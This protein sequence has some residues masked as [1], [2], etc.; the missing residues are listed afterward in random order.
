VTQRRP[1]RGQRTPQNNSGKVCIKDDADMNERGRNWLPI[2]FR[3]KE[4]KRKKEKGLKVW[5]LAN[6]RHVNK[7]LESRERKKTETLGQEKERYKRGEGET[8]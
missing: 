4:A 8:E 5:V 1:S 2:S 3:K 7:N 6:V